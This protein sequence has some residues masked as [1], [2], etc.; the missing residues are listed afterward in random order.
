[1]IILDDLVSLQVISFKELIIDV[2]KIISH[3][4]L[5]K[6]LLVI[7][8]KKEKK[9]SKYLKPENSIKNYYVIHQTV[10]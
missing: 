2:Q 5:M 8:T 6:A 9:E 4:V 3:R 7:A 10:Y 1:M